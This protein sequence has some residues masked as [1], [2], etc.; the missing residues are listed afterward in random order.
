M[1][2]VEKVKRTA[3]VAAPVVKKLATDEQ[4]RKTVINAYGAARHIYDQLGE[5]KELRRVAGQIA[6]DP[7]L[8][9]ELTKQLRDVQKAAKK[10]TRKSHTKRNTLI[11]AGVVGGLLYNPKTGPQTRKWIRERVS[12]PDET[13]EYD[14][15]PPATDGAPAPADTSSPPATGGAPAPADTSSTD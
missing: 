7:K 14:V 9:K 1:A 13:F 4:F 5:D 12:G 6:T 11:L 10:A 3:V 8:Q 15:E 2:K